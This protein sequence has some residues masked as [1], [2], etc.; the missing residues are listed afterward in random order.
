MLGGQDGLNMTRLGLNL[1]HYVNGVARRHGQVSQEMF[2]GYPIDSI[3]NG[4]HSFTW[5]S[6]SFRRVYDRHVPGWS[7]DPF[8]LRHAIKIPPAEIWEAHVEAKRALFAEV[9][10]RTSRSLVEEAL[11]IGFARRATSYKRADLIFRDTRE[12][13]KI[14]KSGGPLQILFAGKAHARDEPGKDVIRRIFRVARELEN[15]VSV[16][17]LENYDMSLA[18]LLTSG[19]DV[20]LNT[21][22]PPL[23]ASGT[24]G[25]KA[26]HNGV[27]SFSILDGWWIE[28]HVEGVTGWSIGSQPMTGT[29]A[30]ADAEDQES[31]ELYQKLR[32]VIVPLYYGNRP[33][34]I[35]VMR[36][37]VAFN[38]SFFN[39][40]R[41]VQQ[42]A[43]N[44]YG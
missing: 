24:S 11:T 30:S 29:A 28:G 40:H 4:V 5:T 2:P 3:T 23:E 17:Y 22:R 38:A 33:G 42:Y 9:H 8:S 13:V 34:W 25:M 41:M 21:P 35:D 18:R 10:R 20:W 43:A 19:A 7:R 14:A 1:S 39:T 44:A 37:T 15:D 12:L 6:D 16:I 31:A 27:P 32:E 36:Q 26:A